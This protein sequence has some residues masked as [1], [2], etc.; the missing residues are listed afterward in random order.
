M[1][2]VKNNNPVILAVLTVV[3]IILLR[4]AWIGDDAA[5]TLR[6]VLNFINGYGPTFNIDER[7][8]AFTHPLW[9]LLISLVSLITGNVFVSTFLLSIAISLFVIWL[10]LTTI[11]SN[12]QY[13]ILAVTVLILSKAYIDFST[14]GLENPLSHLLIVSCVIFGFKSIDREEI[15][16]VLKK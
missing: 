16:V 13:G 14:S 6:S 5:I 9:F 3:L 11:A 4:T 10:L 2:D 7:V 12:F 1:Q 15:K 8:Q